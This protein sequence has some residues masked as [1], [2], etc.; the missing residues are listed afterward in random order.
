MSKFPF[1]L[2]S[3]AAFVVTACATGGPNYSAEQ[4][5]ALDWFAMGVQDGKAGSHMTAVNDDVAGCEAHGISADVETYRK[6]R[7]Q[8]LLTYCQPAALL[9]ATVQG[10]GDAFSCEPFSA[11]EKSAFETGRDTRAAVSRYQGYKGQYDQLVE[12]KQQIN[13]QGAQLTERY[14]IEQDENL[15]QQ[16]A[17]QITQ[18]REQLT[19]VNAAI[20]EADPIMAKEETDY[21]AAVQKFNSLQASFA[22]SAQ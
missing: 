11:D 7:D 13:T 18:L 1:L 16:M 20:A 22:G 8:G 15:K 14:K 3:V 10:V 12:Q 2:S 6:G 19:A 4:C 17:Q 9:E 5:T 21:Q